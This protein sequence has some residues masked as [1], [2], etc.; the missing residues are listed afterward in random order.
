VLLSKSVFWHDRILPALLVA[1]IALWVVEGKLTIYH[2]S[3]FGVED[4]D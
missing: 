2:F 1:D 4:G 3:L